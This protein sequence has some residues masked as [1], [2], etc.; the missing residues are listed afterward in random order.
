MTHLLSD[1]DKIEKIA[2]R[3]APELDGALT[4]ILFRRAGLTLARRH[5]EDIER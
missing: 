2:M 4:E 1:H 3:I 5:V